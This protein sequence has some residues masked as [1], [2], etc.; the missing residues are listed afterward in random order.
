[1]A[2]RIGIVTSHPIQYKIPWYRAL[3]N[4]P[5]IDLTVF[6]AM[7]PDA[8]QQGAGF[9]V[10]FEWDIPL[11]EGYRYQVLENVSPEP[12]VVRFGGCDTPSIRQIVAEGEYDAFITNG[13]V[14]K[15][16]IQALR[17]CRRHGVPCIVRGE[18]NALRRRAWWKRLGHRLL[19]RQYSA[20]LY[21]GQANRDFYLR[22]GVPVDRTFFAP[23]C[24]D[25]DRFAGAAEQMRESRPSIREQWHIPAEAVTFLFCA[26]FEPKKRPQD[27][28]AAAARVADRR[29]AQR[30][31]IHVLMVGDGEL[32]SECERA[33]RA[34]ELPV[35]FTGFLN[36]TEIVQAYVASD[37]LV[38]PSDYGETWG[39]VVNEA[40]A[41][42]LPAIVSDRV[43]CH[44]DLVLPDVTGSVFP[45]G[46]CDALA[47]GLARLASS[48]DGCRGMGASAKAQVTQYSVDRLVQGTVEAVGHVRG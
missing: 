44:S 35:T 32:R 28:L 3:T 26:K 22:H 2:Y 10:A 4:H 33:A 6:Y 12:S 30:N 25:N 46:D 9:G 48:P 16:C 24:V 20:F 45:F 47:R 37:C 1:M 39:L 7:L 21:I 11:L 18:A 17:A 5:E 27:L 41:C 13:W 8:V 38:L 40:M 42:G 43:G 14:V 29:G 31:S 34:S 23:Y 19:L 15:S 36:Q